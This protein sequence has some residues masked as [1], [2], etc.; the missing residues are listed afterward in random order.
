MLI[1]KALRRKVLEGLHIGHQGVTGMLAFAKE[2]FFWPGLDA[3][4]RQ[5]RA[6]CTQCNE[7]APSQSREQLIPT[8]EP[9]IPFQQTVMDLCEIEGNTF[10]VYADRYTGWVEGTSLKS[11]TFK[12]VRQCLITWFSTFGVPEEIATDG[13][14][15]F[16]SCDFDAFLKKWNVR[17]RLSSAYYPQ[18]NGRAEAAVKS[19]KR[20]LTGNINKSTGQVDTDRAA[21]AIMGHRNT[22]NQETGISPAI[23]LY[24]YAIRDHLPNHHRTICRV[25]EEIIDVRE[26]AL[27]K[28]HIRPH[29]QSSRALRPL[30]AGDTVSIQNQS[31][32][33]PLKWNNTGI[34]VDVLPYRQH[35]VLVDGS[36][37]ATLRN[38]RFLRRIEPVCRMPGSHAEPTS[39]HEQPNDERPRSSLEPIVVPLVDQLRPRPEPS[40]ITTPSS[41]PQIQDRDAH[42]NAGIGW[43]RPV[44]S[45]TSPP[46]PPSPPQFTQRDH[47]LDLPRRPSQNHDP[48]SSAPLTASSAPPQPPLGDHPADL[49]GRSGRHQEH[50]RSA[51]STRSSA[52]PRPVQTDRSVDAPRRSSRQ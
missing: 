19:I 25:W 51:P 20:I 2:R 18:S 6:Q 46:S 1:P 45:T 47:L 17:R 9:E 5:I 3:S 32:N 27:A 4:A 26:Q 23:A 44:P 37:R 7:N 41:V 31:G 40:L 48:Q 14:P 52:P 39:G 21:C 43:Q 34:I 49:P 10:L 11:S 29:T 22:P 28:R 12:S 38:R 35:R 36:R 13:G 24:G 16:N 42:I 50:L 30:Q 33:R 8:P 15:P